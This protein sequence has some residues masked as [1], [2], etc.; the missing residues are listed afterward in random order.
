LI[1]Q[2]NI[3]AWRATVPWADDAQVE[4]D[5]VLSRATVELF[6]DDGLNGQIAMRGG[7]SLH[8]LF[9]QPPRRYSEDIDLVQTEGGPIGAVIDAIRANLDP[10]LGKERRK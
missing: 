10:W 3:T 4:Q 9:L 7:T 2:A 8:K 6:A 1:P 5:L